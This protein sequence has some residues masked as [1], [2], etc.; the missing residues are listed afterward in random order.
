MYKV[1]IELKNQSPLSKYR[2]A[3]F[4]S[5]KMAVQ[6][7][8]FFKET[9][10]S[11]LASD[12]KF[13]YQIKENSSRIT[14]E[15]MDYKTIMESFDTSYFGYNVVL[16]KAFENNTL[17]ISCNNESISKLDIDRSDIAL[18]KE[19]SVDM[20]CTNEWVVI[21]DDPLKLPKDNIAIE[22]NELNMIEDY[23]YI[24]ATSIPRV[25]ILNGFLRPKKSLV[26]PLK[27][28][29]KYGNFN[30]VFANRN[31]HKADY[32]LAYTPDTLLAAYRNYKE[33]RRKHEIYIIRSG[34]VYEL[35]NPSFMTP[36]DTV[37]IDTS[38]NI[39]KEVLT[40]SYP[41]DT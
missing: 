12:I 3:M 33:P 8:E 38:I 19:N 30:F 20:A 29:S 14:M 21:K 28:F 40:T 23:K 35:L 37:N 7:I 17:M 9:C 26:K 32:I 24:S 41:T 4:S 5:Y 25:N 18:I 2:T 16:I 10:G 36:F 13:E 34:K 27:F 31:E 11:M 15:K 6:Y 39:P 1:V 22:I